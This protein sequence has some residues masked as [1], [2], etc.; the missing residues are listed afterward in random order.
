MKHHNFV[1]NWVFCFFGSS[2]CFLSIEILYWSKGRAV[3]SHPIPM[4]SSFPLSLIL[5]LLTVCQ[6]LIFF[7]YCNC[8]LELSFGKALFKMFSFPLQTPKMPAYGREAPS[9]NYCLFMVISLDF[10]TTSILVNWM[11]PGNVPSKGNL[12]DCPVKW[13]LLCFWPH[14]AGTLP[15]ASW[16]QLGN[17][18]RPGTIPRKQFG[19]PPCFQGWKSLTVQI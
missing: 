17:Q 3:L 10:W 12:I 18:H 14:P 9:L 16:T 4:G 7:P 19:C 15:N 1:N 8:H 13:F 11:A 6:C 5:T 2:P